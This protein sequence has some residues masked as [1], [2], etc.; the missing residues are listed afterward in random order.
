MQEFSNQL[1]D[2]QY[3]AVV[4]DPKKVLQ[5]NAPPGTGKTKV[6]I[7]RIVYLLTVAK[8]PPESI[9][10]TT[11]GVKAKEE[12]VDRLSK[13]LENTD[14][15]YTQVNVGTFHGICYGILRKHGYRI[16]CTDLEVISDDDQEKLMK[17]MIENV[18]PH[19]LDAASSFLRKKNLM[20][21]NK[22]GAYVLSVKLIKSNISKL[23]SQGQTV[24]DYSDAHDVDQALLYFYENYQKAMKDQKKVDFDDLLLQAY[25]L[26]KEH[27]CLKQVQHVLVDEFQ[28]TSVL[29]MQLM[30]LFARGK[31]VNCNGITVVGDP[32]Q[33]IYAFRDAMPHNF[34][35]MIRISPVPVTTITL[36]QNYRSTQRIVDS[37]QNLMKQQQKGRDNTT[38]L[39][40]QYDTK[41]GP[42]FHSYHN[43]KEE[44]AGLV[45]EIM[46]L[47]SLPG[48]FSYN[49]FSI[50]VRQRRQIPALERALI[51]ARLPYYIIK[52][53]SFWERREVKSI[54]NN[55]KLV[56]SDYEPFALEDALLYP[57]RGLGKAGFEK[58]KN[59]L[60]DEANSFNQLKKYYNLLPTKGRKVATKL[61]ET[62]E[63][64]RA[65][66]ENGTSKSNMEEIF[67]YIYENSGLK[68]ELTV[69]KKD[70]NP[71]Q[72]KA[73]VQKSGD[74]EEAPDLSSPKHMNVM[75]VKEQLM[76]F[77][78][79]YSQMNVDDEEEDNDFIF[80]LSRTSSALASKVEDNELDDLDTAE[81]VEKP[82]ECSKTPEIIYDKSFV[83]EFVSSVRLYG[84][85][86][87]ED[88]ESQFKEGRVTVCT[89]HKAKGCEWPVVFV[90]GCT[91]GTNPSLFANDVEDEDSED[92]SEAANNTNK[93]G[94]YKKTMDE[95][96]NEERRVF[97]VAL[98]R[99]KVQ[100]YLSSVE[101]SSERNHETEYKL[102]R[103]R[104]ITPGF[105]KTVEMAQQLFDNVENIK[106]FYKTMGVKF[107]KNISNFS[108]QQLIDD[109]DSYLND[110]RLHF[111]WMGSQ[112]YVK[113][114]INL[115]FNHIS[116]SP[117]K[118][119]SGFLSAAEQLGSSLSLNATSHNRQTLAPRPSGRSR[120]PKELPNIRTNL[121]STTSRFVNKSPTRKTY[122]PTK[123]LNLSPVRRKVYAPS[124]APVSNNS[125]NVSPEKK[126]LKKDFKIAGSNER[127]NQ[128]KPSL[129]LPTGRTPTIDLT[130]AEILHD[131]EEETVDHRPFLTSANS[132]L[133]RS[134]KAKLKK[135][136]DDVKKEHDENLSQH[137]LKKARKNNKKNT[138]Q[139]PEG[140]DIFS[141]LKK[142]KKIDR[143]YIEID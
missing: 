83:R 28:D 35:D 91:E 27:N 123:N 136:G 5:V 124:K 15:N 36:N 89:T 116:A 61:I 102:V 135:E 62:I 133:E 32:D 76:E 71:S 100:L 64:A 95:L 24:K 131:P 122:A 126:K 25:T 30:F 17:K 85:K 26:L 111:H 57:A 40:A 55:I 46:Y 88:E 129:D 105:L 41:F 119:S 37:C 139:P 79:D 98:S 53:Q 81:V 50:L 125:P 84:D 68:H 114:G 34:K 13:A 72:Q 52:G 56:L 44:A 21:M 113:N 11:F 48:I 19:I 69:N 33:C 70:T 7:S 94:K 118:Y 143:A 1:N 42:V 93:P 49:D 104:F 121:D 4:F 38:K 120:Q 18:P 106:S 54:M 142:G 130:A 108:L 138:Q 134:R 8:L 110:E 29:Q 117:K 96:L 51:E 74:F 107:Q 22:D 66:F 128:K 97:Y 23:K 60:S 78:N 132:L 9:I 75:Q 43:F 31:S 10:C 140:K 137:P 6:I 77:S 39:F 90:P 82:N 99:A 73:S 47:K 63:T 12:I 101:T 115:S 59:K 112:V 16:G 141:L 103:S 109:Y 58:I 3:R 20:M 65:M 2:N 92:E 14:I 67:D 86:E 45:S 127:K 80:S 87:S